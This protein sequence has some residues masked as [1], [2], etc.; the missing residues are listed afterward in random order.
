MLLW[1]G[2]VNVGDRVI[3]GRQLVGIDNFGRGRWAIAT[4]NQP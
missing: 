1:I 2:F 3:P 4:P